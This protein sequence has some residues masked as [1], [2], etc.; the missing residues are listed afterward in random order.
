[1]A[2]SSISLYPPPLS[3]VSKNPCRLS[4]HTRDLSLSFPLS[5][6]LSSSRAIQSP[7]S[8]HQISPNSTQLQRI[9]AVAEDVLLTDATPIED[10][11]QIVST[12]GDGVTIIVQVLVFIAFIGLSILTL[13]VIYITVTDFLQ[14]RESEKFEK[15]EESKRKKSGKKR[16][17]RARAGPRGFGQKID[18]DDGDD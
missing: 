18:D 1:M 16:K 5:S 7:N 8:L 17:V 10:S 13:G 14:K 9:S 11:Q 6:S 4:L 15:E 3:C 12:D 2:T